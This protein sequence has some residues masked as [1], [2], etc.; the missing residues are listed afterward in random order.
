MAELRAAARAHTELA[1]TTLATVAGSKTAPAAAR[2]TAAEALL[3]RGWGRPAQP[4]DINDSRPL[5]GVP[6]ERLLAALEG[7]AA[8]REDEG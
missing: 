3:N 7:L 5:A 1:I 2:V 4:V 6:A 8:A